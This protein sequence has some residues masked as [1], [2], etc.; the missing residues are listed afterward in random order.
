[1]NKIGID[2]IKRIELLSDSEKLTKVLEFI[3]DNNGILIYKQYENEYPA[4]FNILR[5]L[6]SDGNIRLSEPIKN[7][8]YYSLYFQNF[9]INNIRNNPTPKKLST[10]QIIMIIGGLICA[11]SAIITIIWY[12]YNW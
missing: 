11:I 3:K 6:E 8:Y 12:F 4:F 9:L 7:G 1:M 2:F 10:L 5:K